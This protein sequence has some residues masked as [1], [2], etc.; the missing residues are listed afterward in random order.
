MFEDTKLTTL[1][2][3]IN[4]ERG[5]ATYESFVLHLA[6]K[7]WMGINKIYYSFLAAGQSSSDA[8][9]NVTIFYRAIF[10]KKFPYSFKHFKSEITTRI[11]NM[12]VTWCEPKKK[13]SGVEI[14]LARIEAKKDSSFYD[15]IA[16]E[17][18]K[19]LQ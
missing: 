12:P 3:I 4:V 11:S 1:L 18:R 2:K 13:L 17:V 14:Y 15:K 16:F 7:N 8:W 19:R 5:S 10:K 6:Q 9:N